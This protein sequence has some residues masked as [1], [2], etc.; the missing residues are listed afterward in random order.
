LIEATLIHAAPFQN[1]AVPVCQE[2][3]F[4]N[5]N[6][7]I[8]GPALIE[9]TSAIVD[10]FVT[11]MAAV[12]EIPLT[13]VTVAPS[14]TGRATETEIELTSVTVEAFVAFTELLPAPE[15]E[16]DRVTVAAFV[17]GIEAETTIE[18][19]SVRVEE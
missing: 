5:L 18:S 6:P 10:A 8:A 19:A 14:D 17:I 11:G 13:R 2:D 1:F 4:Q 9:F 3:P 12:D 7:V 16:S 15:I